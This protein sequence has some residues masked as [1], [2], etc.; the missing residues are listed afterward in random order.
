MFSAESFKSEVVHFMD[1]FGI[2]DLSWEYMSFMTISPT[3][4][5]IK[6]Y[7]LHLVLVRFFFMKMGLELCLAFRAYWP[8]V[9]N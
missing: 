8:G 2:V 4:F 5:M 1:D 6:T 3:A 7:D 9:G